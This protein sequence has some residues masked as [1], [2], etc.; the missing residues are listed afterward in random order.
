MGR[1]RPAAL[2]KGRSVSAWTYARQTILNPRSRACF[3]KHPLRASRMVLGVGQNQLLAASERLIASARQEC[4][5]CGWRGRRFRTFISPGSVI[6]ASICPQCGSFDR[7]RHLVLGVRDELASSGEIPQRILGLSLSPAMTYLLAHE[8]LGRCFRSDY[9]R[10]DPRCTPEMVVDL[11]GAGIADGAFDW[12]VCSHVLE[13]IPDLAAAVDELVRVL[14]PGG[15]AWIQ[16]ALQQG[17]DRSRRIPL[18]PGDFDAHAWRFGADFDD[19][20]ARP[21]WQTTCVRAAA[22]TAE[23]RQKHGIH[24]VERYWLARRR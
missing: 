5:L 23:A 2:A 20:L 14:R 21:G 18:D 15:V 4:P 6:P 1:A 10:R 8:G 12:V 19:L 24:P 16:V 3:W 17:L 9:D 7:H 22:L 11:S 13:H